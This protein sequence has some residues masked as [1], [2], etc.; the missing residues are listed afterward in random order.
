M[1]ARGPH[2]CQGECVR[3]LSVVGDGPGVWM[4]SALPSVDWRDLGKQ[5]EWHPG[6]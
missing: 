4:P 1:R 3:D 6:C 5:G 2:Y